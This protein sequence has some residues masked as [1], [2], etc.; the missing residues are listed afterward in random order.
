MDRYKL[1][2]KSWITIVILAILSAVAIRFN[3]RPKLYVGLVV[4]M[5]GVLFIGFN[6]NKVIGAILGVLTIG[7]G[8]ILR[9]YYPEVS[10]LTGEKLEAFL[11]G[12]NAYNE[13]LSQYFILFIILGGLIGLLG[14][15]VGEITKEE[16]TNKFSTNRITYIAMFVALSV[17][18]N[19]ARVGSISFGGFPIILSGYFLGPINGFIVGALAD[20]I[21]YIIRPSAGGGFNPLFILTSAL[22]GFIP[23][24]VTRLLGEKYPNY[25]FPK[26]FAG[27]FVGQML[28]SVIMVPFFRVMLYGENTFI[29]FASSAFIRQAFNMPLYAFLINTVNES[30]RR[31]VNFERI[32]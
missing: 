8:F 2:M 4:A 9:G 28:T 10:K 31:T 19:T 26:L 22:T 1:S 11:K 27:I 3:T 20:V 32:K 15:A 13:F 25:N 17:A 14:G 16:R 30:L 29:F 6:S 21:A 18:I 5:I 7:S 24:V 23:V 12:Y